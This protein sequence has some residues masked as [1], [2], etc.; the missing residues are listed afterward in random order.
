MKNAFGLRGDEELEALVLVQNDVGEGLLVVPTELLGD[1]GNQLFVLEVGDR[2]VL[3]QPADLAIRKPFHR[4]E[5]LG[6]RSA[7]LDPVDSDGRRRQVF[8]D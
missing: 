1:F 3:H 6:V 5:D 8:W 7:L 2:L 4:L